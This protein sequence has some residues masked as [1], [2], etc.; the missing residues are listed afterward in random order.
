MLGAP[1]LKR[2]VVPVKAPVEGGTR[3]AEVWEPAGDDHDWSA[4]PTV[5]DQRT[6]P[7]YAGSWLEGPLAMRQFDLSLPA[8][9]AAINQMLAESEPPDA[10]RVA[11]E[12]RDAVYCK[13]GMTWK[14]LMTYRRI[15]YR[16]LVKRPET[17]LTAAEKAAEEQA[18]TQTPYVPETSP[19]R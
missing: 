1:V 7:R 19:D 11:I 6:N 8:D 13:M 15:S 18:C 14:I 12:S 4:E 10:P 2:A 9:Q 16:R 3:P 5:A 17:Q